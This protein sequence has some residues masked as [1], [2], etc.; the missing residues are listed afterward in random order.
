MK[1]AT[2]YYWKHSK[3]SKHETWEYA[4]WGDCQ[5]LAFL[6]ESGDPLR[7]PNDFGCIRYRKIK[8]KNNR[9]MESAR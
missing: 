3:R 9:F 6:T 5:E 1:C 2:C 7:V 4:R 8:N